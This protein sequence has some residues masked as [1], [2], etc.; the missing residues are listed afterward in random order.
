MG[1]R[2]ILYNVHKHQQIEFDIIIMHN[3]EL[4]LEK[5]KKLAAYLSA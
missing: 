2:K 3:Y 4:K 1:G 5:K